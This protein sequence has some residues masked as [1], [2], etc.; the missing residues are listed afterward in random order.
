[1]NL[2]VEANILEHLQITVIV[3]Q[4]DKLYQRRSNVM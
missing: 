3:A 1:M 4:Y 2:F